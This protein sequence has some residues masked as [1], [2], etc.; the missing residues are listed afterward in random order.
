MEYKEIT[1]TNFKNLYNIDK[2][3]ITKTSIMEYL[4]TY[5]KNKQAV[6]FGVRKTSND[7]APV[8]F[9]E[10]AKKQDVFNQMIL[11]KIKAIETRLDNIVKLNNLKE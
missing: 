4:K 8:W 7:V 3:L 1:K 5:N 11:Q 9:Q 2:V 6:A 10:F